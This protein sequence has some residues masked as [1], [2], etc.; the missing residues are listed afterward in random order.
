ML[1]TIVF[2]ICIIILLGRLFAS[3]TIL[4]EIKNKC[5]DIKRNID[6]QDKKN[7]ILTQKILDMENNIDLIETCIRSGLKYVKNNEIVVSI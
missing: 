4:S 6:I 5:E 1:Y 2:W 3:M 7:S